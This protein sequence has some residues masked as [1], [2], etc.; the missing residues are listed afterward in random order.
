MNL[1]SFA[2]FFAALRLCVRTLFFAIMAATV[3]VVSVSAQTSLSLWPYYVEVAPE[4][5]GGQLYDLVVPLPVID[6]ARADLADLRL[7]DSSNREIPYAIRVRKDIDARQ[8]IP[9]RLFNFGFAGPATSEVTVDLGENHGEHNEIEVETNGSNFRRQVVIEGSDTG[10]EWRTLSND[11]VLFSF[12]SQNNVAESQKVSYPTSRYRYLRVKVS[13]DPMTD[14]Q[15]PQVTNVKV[16]MAVREKGFLS[17]WDVPVPSYQLQRNQGAHATVWTLDLGGRVPCDRLSLE[18]AEDSF[19][20][21]FQVET[22]DD[23]QDIRLIA[24]GDLTRHY[25]EEKKPLVIYFSD[26]AV[27]RKLRL[28][29]TD[30]SNPTLNIQSINASAPARQLVFE[31]KSPTSQPLRLYF[32]NEKVPAPHYDFEKEVA[33]R[34]SREPVHSRLG[35]VSANHEYKPEPKPLT[36]RAPWLIYVVLAVS[37]IALAFI[38]LSLARTTTRLN[39]QRAD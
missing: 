29:I 25:G 10:R 19:S 7:F 20:R 11:G 17:T 21:P 34:L 14:N 18:I 30:Y 2:S 31:L 16:M 39:A 8:E 15:T 12:A 4:R 24:T 35:D 26:E 5:A 36:E 33:V 6:K 3:L 9:T 1:P 37:G 22:I 28:Q 27:A 38:L 23:P 13:R 32:G